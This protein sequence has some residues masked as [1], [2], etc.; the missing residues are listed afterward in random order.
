M[1]LK[2]ISYSSLNPRQKENFNFQKISAI[3]ADFG[4]VT[5]RLS[6]DW[7]GADF[8]ALHIDGVT[9]ARVQLKSRLTFNENYRGKGL[10]IAFSDRES[11]YLYPHDEFLDQLLDI[12]TIGSS[13]SWS[14]QGLYSIPKLTKQ[15]LGLLEKYRISG[16]ANP[17]AE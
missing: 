17:V 10:W 6:D 9:V 8:I 2:R 16:D 5:L 3:L 12:K 14:V 1:E 15:L 13:S 7:Q 11:W 4:F